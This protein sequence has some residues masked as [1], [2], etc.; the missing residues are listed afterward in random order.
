M[1]Q[2]R[3]LLPLLREKCTGMLEQQAMDQLKKS[4]RN[5]C[6]ESGYVQQTETLTVQSDGTI[7]LDA[8]FD[9]YI[10]SINV[11]IETKDGKELVKGVGYKVDAGNNVT[12]APS[13]NEVQVTFSVVP[14][15]PM[16]DSIEAND[17][18]CR[19]WPDE[20]AAGAA[21]LLRL[22]PNQPWSDASL[23]DFYKRDFVKGH[24]EAFQLRVAANDEI[25]FQ[26]TSNRNFF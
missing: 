25:Q 15:L 23:A 4:Y 26:T 10:G 1:A 16:D 12:I 2:L 14:I 18:I 6:L 17:D 22:I 21:S 20:L 11:V 13:Y 9:Y 24:R 8:D 7:A 5:F 3:D 19:R